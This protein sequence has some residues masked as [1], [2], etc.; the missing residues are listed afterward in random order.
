MFFLSTLLAFG[1]S[2]TTI[3]YQLTTNG[4]T[5]S[6]E[7]FVSGFTA[8]QPCTNN[9]ALECSDEIAIDFDATVFS[10]ISNGVAPTGFSVLLFQPNN[11]PQAPGDYAALAVVANP[12]ASPFSVDFTLTGS[13]TP[14]PQ[15]FNINEFNSSVLFEGVAQSPSL[16]TPL[17]NNVPE[18]ASAL[19]IAGGIIIGS[20]FLGSRFLRLKRARSI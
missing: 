18:P 5:G 6:Y 2:A 17:V 10:G 16:T 1:M 4:T 12:S 7:Y 19:L 20:V 13:G 15:T 14:G 9:P 8:M 11:P 3:T